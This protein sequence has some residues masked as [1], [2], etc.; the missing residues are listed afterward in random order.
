MSAA[1]CSLL[2]RVNGVWLGE[3]SG[4]RRGTYIH[5]SPWIL[6]KVLC[7]AGEADGGKVYS[8]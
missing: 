8:S 5:T 4:V 2:R 7:T 6:R 3:M 1:S